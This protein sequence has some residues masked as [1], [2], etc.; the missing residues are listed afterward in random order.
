[1]SHVE[2]TR[3]DPELGPGATRV[4]VDGTNLSDSISRLSVDLTADRA[5]VTVELHAAERQR[6]CMADA[7]LIIGEA[8]VALLERHGW[9]PPTLSA[10]TPT[11]REQFDAALTNLLAAAGI[12][13]QDASTA[14]ASFTARLA[15]ASVDELHAMF[16]PDAIRVAKVISNV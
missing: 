4:V 9:R 1:M 16:G 2:I 11:P 5:R 14:V 15:A 13:E 8:T 7:E 3:P 12:V 6:L 10:G